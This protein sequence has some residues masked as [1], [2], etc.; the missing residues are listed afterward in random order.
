MP[1]SPAPP[2]PASRKSLLSLDGWAVLAATV[3]IVLILLGA[4]PHVPW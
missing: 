1:T 2:H 4:L 3:F